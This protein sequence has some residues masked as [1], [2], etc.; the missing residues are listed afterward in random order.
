MR[1]KLTTAFLL[2][3]TALC[4]AQEVQLSCQSL[5]GLS[6]VSFTTG[7]N[8]TFFDVYK[9]RYYNASQSGAGGAQMVI[10]VSTNA[11]SSYSATGYVVE[12]LSQWTTEG[13]ASLSTPGNRANWFASVDAADTTGYGTSGEMILFNQGGGSNVTWYQATVE[14]YET[15]GNP[16]GMRAG[17]YWNASPGTLVNGAKFAMTTGTF[18]AGKIC[19]AGVRKQ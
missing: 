2:A 16:I 17:G 18:T 1:I 6:E 12:S 19:M 3:L 10:T 7:W 8:S 14:K 11:G 13:L 4:P 5:S 15:G 9:F